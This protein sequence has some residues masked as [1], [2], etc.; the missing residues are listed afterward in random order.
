MRNGKTFVLSG[1]AALALAGC[2]GLWLAQPLHSLLVPSPYGGVAQIRY[3]G[4]IPPRVAFAPPLAVESFPAASPFMA[5]D[6]ISA[7]MDLEMAALMDGAMVPPAPLG[8][9]GMLN[10]DVRG[11]PPGAREYSYV[12]TVG[13]DGNYC[14]RS[15]E[16]TRSGPDGRPYVVTHQSGECRA[17]GS[18][19]YGAALFAPPHRA[20]P[21]IEVRN[22]PARQRS[23]PDMLNVAYPAGA[24]KPEPP[25]KDQGAPFRSPSAVFVAPAARFHPRSS[26]I[27]DSIRRSG[28]SHIAATA[29]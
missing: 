9:D 22:W 12:S 16:I 18:V 23:E 17:I 20:P 13:R 3:A 10:V 28:T 21:T 1:A 24:V 2:A 6:R 8:P 29:T 15:V 27:R 4:D 26:F 7:Q 14:S 25:W 11:L 19:G 5:L